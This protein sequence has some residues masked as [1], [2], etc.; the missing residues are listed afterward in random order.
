MIQISGVSD[1]HCEGL[2]TSGVEREKGTKQ[3]FHNLELFRVE[4]FNAEYERSVPQVEGKESC[5]DVARTVCTEVGITEGCIFIIITIIMIFVAI[6]I[7]IIYMLF[8]IHAILIIILT[9]R[10]IIVVVI[11]I[12]I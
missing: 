3:D 5:V 9:A 11:I 8:I 4:L 10:I 6:I 2:W 7:I 1:H 12:Y